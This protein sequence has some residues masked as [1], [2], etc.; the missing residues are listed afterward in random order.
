[1]KRIRRAGSVLLAVIMALTV[2]ACGAKPAEPPFE[3]ERNDAVISEA[4]QETTGKTSGA[5]DASVSAEGEEPETSQSPVQPEP[6]GADTPEMGLS[7]TQSEQNEAQEKA[8]SV[9]TISISCAS[10]LEHPDW[11]NMEKVDLVPA[12]GVLLPAEEVGIEEGESVFDLLKRVCREKK[13]HMEFS[14]TPLYQSAYIEGIGNLYEFDCGE[15]SGWMYRVNGAFPNVGCSRWM[16]SDGDVVE[17]VY[18]CDF[19]ADVGGRVGA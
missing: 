5:P 10:I 18:T 7:D 6:D 1:M 16:L 3:P 12:D 19:G 13:I 11:L 15:G 14:E 9:C 17:W 2:A 4:E 8:A